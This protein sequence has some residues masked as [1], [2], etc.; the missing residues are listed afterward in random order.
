MSLNAS[1]QQDLAAEILG[2][3]VWADEVVGY[4]DCPGIDSHPSPDGDRDCR[5]KLD[6]VSTISCLHSSCQEAIA[7][8][9]NPQKRQ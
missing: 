2:G 3:I 1:R 8:V 7:E 4:C 6:G 5:V 9:A